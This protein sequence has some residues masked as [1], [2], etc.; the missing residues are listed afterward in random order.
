MCSLDEQ[1]RYDRGFMA[2]YS[3][4][5]RVIYP[6]GNRKLLAIAQVRDYEQDE[7]ALASRR[8]F[9]YEFDARDYM[10]ELS[11]RHGIDFEGAQHFLD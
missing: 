6:C 2:S 11:E 8:E 7:W 5:W 3:C 9:I 4:P 1:P 10:M